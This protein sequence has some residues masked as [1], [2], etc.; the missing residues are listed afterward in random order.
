MKTFFGR[1][2]VNEK[3]EIFLQE[4]SG[5]I[6]SVETH[7][8]ASLNGLFLRNGYIV[9]IFGEIDEKKFLKIQEI[10]ILHRPKNFEKVYL[11]DKNWKK[12]L[13]SQNEKNLLKKRAK[14]KFLTHKF[15]DNLGFLETEV[16]IMIS[17]P[18]TEWSLSYFETK[19]NFQNGKKK[20]MF[21]STSPE[22]QHKKLLVAGFDKIY[23]LTKSFRN[24]EPTDEKHNFEFSILE[25]YRSFA[26]YMDV[27]KDTIE[28]LKFLN[29]QI[30]KTDF[31]EFNGKKFDFEKV[32]IFEIEK[33]FEKKFGKKLDLVAQ[34]LE[35][36]KKFAKDLNL[37]ILEEDSIS[38][39]FY[40][41]F[42]EFF[43]DE[44][45]KSHKIVVVKNYPYFEA[46]LARRSVKNNFYAERFEI[47]VGG[48][49]IANGFS[50]LNDSNEQKERFIEEGKIRK[51]LKKQKT[52]L[53]KDFFDALEIG[54]PPSGGVAIGFDRICQLVLN[55][56]D[57]NDILFFPFR[58]L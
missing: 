20:K 45:S 23:S 57:I 53:D 5:E 52:P 21:L 34:N 22:L 51:D 44:I 46:S 58:D 18:A 41:I 39:I 29:F 43:E 56:K 10:K 54:M 3:K 2:F 26:D 55:Q 13:L 36:F 28:L 14:L 38:D 25:F 27:C 30:N 16:P 7:F 32:K 49:E 17:A 19:I 37:E 1:I 33:E 50:E 9:Q 6:F 15:F 8:N 31:L 35:D 11:Q 40:K 48:L 42:I 24:A 4:K 47:F 12:F